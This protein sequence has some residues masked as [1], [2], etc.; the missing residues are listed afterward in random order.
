MVNT[1]IYIY[2]CV[3][4]LQFCNYTIIFFAIMFLYICC[5]FSDDWQNVT[6]AIEEIYIRW[7]VAAYCVTRIHKHTV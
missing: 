7:P 4:Q 2:A 1:Y 3:F 5:T 6:K